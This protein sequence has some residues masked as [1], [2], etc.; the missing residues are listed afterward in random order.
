MSVAGGD[1]ILAGHLFRVV[2]RHRRFSTKA[3]TTETGF[4]RLD[5]IP[6]YAG[7][8]YLVG[9]LRLRPTM[10]TTTDRCKF[11]IRFTEDGTNATISSPSIL[12][13]AEGAHSI[14]QDLWV[15]F[16]P[17]VDETLSLL[18]TCQRVGGATSTS[19]IQAD[20]SGVDL[21]LCMFDPNGTA[22]SGTDV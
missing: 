13:R 1:E 16:Y 9:A 3:Y 6:V 11:Q 4:I 18:L 7:Y 14:S 2:K 22:S 17:V 5:D 15:P 10:A 21:F 12:G 19:T 20:E 8:G